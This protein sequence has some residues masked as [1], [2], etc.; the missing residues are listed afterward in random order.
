MEGFMSG[1]PTPVIKKHEHQGDYE[2]VFN[3]YALSLADIILGVAGPSKLI[4]GSIVNS[5]G[6]KGFTETMA[7]GLIAVTSCL[8]WYTGRAIHQVTKAKDASGCGGDCSEHYRAE[9]QK[10]IAIMLL[11]IGCVIVMIGFKVLVV[12]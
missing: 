10:S 11:N 6:A 2:N 3:V 9:Y 5:H 4:L 8:L 12:F 1:A 7:V